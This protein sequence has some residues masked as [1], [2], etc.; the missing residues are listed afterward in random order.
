MN[1]TL[2]VASNKLG[3]A[4]TRVLSVIQYMFQLQ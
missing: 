1:K 2:L 3:L 4:L